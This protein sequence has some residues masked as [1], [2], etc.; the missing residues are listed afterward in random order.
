MKDSVARRNA[1]NIDAVNGHLTQN[2]VNTTPP[3]SD[4]ESAAS[5]CNGTDGADTDSDKDSSGEEITE[6][7]TKGTGNDVFVNMTGKNVGFRHWHPTSLPA[8]NKLSTCT[9]GGAWEWTSTTFDKH[10][11]W[12]PSKVYPG[13]SGIKFCQRLD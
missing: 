12:A 1:V 10:E 4:Y 11:G 13:Y 8:A 2:G 3:H 6:I 9:D 7:G 5:S